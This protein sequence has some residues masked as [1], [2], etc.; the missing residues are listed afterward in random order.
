MC[1]TSS[2]HKVVTW[3]FAGD[4]LPDLSRYGKVLEAV[5]PRVKVQVDRGNLTGML[6][7]VLSAHAVEDVSVE[8]PPLEE[9]IAEVFAIA[10]NEALPTEESTA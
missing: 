6:S 8:D 5:A 10:D 9:V 4:D 7:M 3:Q 2:Q 1:H